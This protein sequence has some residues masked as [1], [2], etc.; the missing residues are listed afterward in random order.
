MLG[1]VAGV[2]LAWMAASV[3][4][5]AWS[6]EVVSRYDLDYWFSFVFFGN[7]VLWITALLPFALIRRTVG[8]NA[9]SSAWRAAAS[10]AA[11]GVLM[12][13]FAVELGRVLNIEG[14]EQPFLTDLLAGA[15]PKWPLFAGPGAVGGLTCWL[16]EFSSAPAA[17]A[18][19]FGAAKPLRWAAAALSVALVLAASM[20]LGQW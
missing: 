15:V 10:G 6:E 3:G 9:F 2:S 1:Y 14:P 13:P 16:I 20:L 18:Q 8:V 11:V 7:L 4:G 5:M 12:M 17:V 19:Y